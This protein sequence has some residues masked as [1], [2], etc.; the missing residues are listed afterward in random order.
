LADENRQPVG[1]GEEFLALENHTPAAAKYVDAMRQARRYVHRSAILPQR[2]VVAAGRLV[3]K[4]DEVPHLVVLV[5]LQA[6][7]LIGI[8]GIEA[9]IREYGRQLVMPL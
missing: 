7:V 5:D 4:D 3:V 9:A 1:L 2:R 6:V 8:A